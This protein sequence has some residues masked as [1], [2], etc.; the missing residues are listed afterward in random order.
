MLSGKLIDSGPKI[1]TSLG[2]VTPVSKQGF[3]SKY[4]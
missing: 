3:D 2:A 4:R 1:F